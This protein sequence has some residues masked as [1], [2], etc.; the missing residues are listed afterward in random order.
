MGFH[1]DAL[2]GEAWAKNKSGKRKSSIDS[3]VLEATV[4]EPPW[5]RALRTWSEKRKIEEPT[6]KKRGEPRKREEQIWSRSRRGDRGERFLKRVTERK[7]G[8]RPRR[9]E[10]KRS[11]AHL[12]AY[13][14][15]KK[16]EQWWGDND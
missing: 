10:E 1:R 4:E 2:H 7:G 14:K 9:K 13:V 11:R 12:P 3:D 16:G 5:F 15:L 8:E 6:E